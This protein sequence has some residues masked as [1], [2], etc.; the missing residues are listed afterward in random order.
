[1]VD[2][3]GIPGWDKVGQ[4]A[5]ALLALDGLGL[6]KAQAREVKRLHGQLGEYDQRPLQFAP[7]QHKRP[8]GRYGRSKRVDDDIGVDYMRR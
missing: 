6:T 3:K 7:H 8:L 1:M 5:R 2:P 4:L